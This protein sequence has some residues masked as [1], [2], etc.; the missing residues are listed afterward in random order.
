LC[1]DDLKAGYE[2]RMAKLKKAA[3][4]AGEALA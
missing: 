4:L 3:K 1:F 2:L